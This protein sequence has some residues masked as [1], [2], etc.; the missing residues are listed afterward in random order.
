MKFVQAKTSKLLGNVECPLLCPTLS[1]SMRRR[2]GLTVYPFV[3]PRLRIGSAY[4]GRV[5]HLASAIWRRGENRTVVPLNEA[6]TRAKLIDPALYGRNER[7]APLVRISGDR[8]V[9]WPEY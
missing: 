4:H 9:L 1:N 8:N 6:D 3:P 2:S 7:N 5:T